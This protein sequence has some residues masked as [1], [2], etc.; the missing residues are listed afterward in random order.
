MQPS[1]FLNLKT[2]KKTTYGEFQYETV[3]GSS[4]ADFSMLNP[5]LGWSIIIP[6][7]GQF[8]EKEILSLFSYLNGNC[9]GWTNY[10]CSAGHFIL[11]PI[12]SKVIKPE[13]DGQGCAILIEFQDNNGNMC[14]LLMSDNKDYLQNTQGM[15]EM[16][17]GT[18]ETKEECIKREVFEE[19]KIDLSSLDLVEVGSYGFYKDVPL[20]NC[21]WWCYTTIFFASL[22]WDKVEHLFPD[23]LMANHI[24]VVFSCRY[25]FSLDE[26]Q[27][28]FVI[29][30]GY[31]APEEFDL[32]K[33][34]N[35]SGEVSLKYQKSHHHRQMCEKFMNKEELI[36]PPF[37]E[38]FT[39]SKRHE[40]ALKE[41][42]LKNSI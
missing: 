41:W 20:V 7:E 35:K 29:P 13:G 38:T 12:L 9:A 36:I 28:V 2:T 4:A 24:T 23:G 21:G 15:M 19:L 3:Y 39:F 25:D 33:K 42:N 27:Q 26:T 1:T 30:K 16:R 31:D 14:D 40:E 17:Q 34:V 10:Y 8:K 5:K 11:S 32:F 37:L 6:Q 22:S 18:M